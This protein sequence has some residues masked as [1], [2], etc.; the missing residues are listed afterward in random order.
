MARNVIWIVESKNC[1]AFHVSKASHE[2]NGCTKRISVILGPLGP[3]WKNIIWIRSSKK[4]FGNFFSHPPHFSRTR[5]YFKNTSILF[6]NL[7]LF[8]RFLDY[9]TR[10]IPIYMLNSEPSLISMVSLFCLKTSL[11]P[12]KIWNSSI[13]WFLKF[14]SPNYCM[15]KVF[16]GLIISNPSKRSHD[17]KITMRVFSKYWKVRKKREGWE[18]K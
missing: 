12:S 16:S 17:Y 3:I 15:I 18:K 9:R 11:S 5:K 1:G 7:T 13:L 4:Y 14:F 6:Y 2:R 10:N 8:S